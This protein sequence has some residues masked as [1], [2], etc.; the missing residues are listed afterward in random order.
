[1]LPPGLKTSREVTLY[2]DSVYDSLIE[3]GRA[4]PFLYPWAGVGAFVVLGYILIDHRNSPTLKW[5]RYPIFAW[6][7]SFQAWVIATNKARH[8]A[9]AFGVGLLSAWGVLWV[10]MIMVVNDCQTD[11]KRIERKPGAE[12]KGRRTESTLNGSTSNGAISKSSTQHSQKRDHSDS[13]D[14]PDSYMWQSCPTSFVERLDWIADAFCNFRGVGWNW[15]TSTVP[16][17]S[18]SSA[19]QTDT[20]SPSGIRRLTSKPALLKSTL[21]SLVIGYLT[22]DLIKLLITHDAYFWGCMD[23]APPSYLPKIISTSH[24]LLKSYRLLIS[25]GGMYFALW[26]IFKLG[27]LLFCGL[28]G[29]KWI[30]AR[31]EAW[32]NPPDM[33]GSFRCVFEQGLA[34]WWSGWWHQTFRV[35]FNAHSGWLL[36]ALEVDGRSEKGR[37]IAMATAFFLSGCLHACASFTQ[38][39]ETRPLMGPMRFFLLQP[40]G[41]LFQMWS[42]AHLDRMGIRQRTPRVLRRLVNFVYVHV[43][44]YFTA[45]ILVDDFAKGGVWL[46]E[47]VVISPL[48][49][50]GLGGKDDGWF[51]WWDGILFWRSGK[52]WWDTGIGI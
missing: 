2:Y 50:L 25:L 10:S 15:Q 27:P 23:A 22:L 34:G 26:E 44:L 47:P 1:M 28:L 30:G 33:F 12:S 37:V 14:L 6:L 11:F 46:Y 5:L 9:G 21:T 49:G 52:H 31:G 42:V 40:C 38:L 36:A 3:S 16:S 20:T 18:S 24:V 8:P 39:G 35:A 41:I 7:V 29:P 4:V 13:V 43:W 32:M 48:R 17:L 19:D 45:P 51:C